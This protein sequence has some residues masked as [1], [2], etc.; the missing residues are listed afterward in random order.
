MKRILKTLV[1]D[2]INLLYPAT[3]IGCD[4][5]LET[6][7]K[8]PVCKMCFEK[9][10][11]NTPPYCSKCGK[12]M[13]K[14]RTYKPTCSDCLRTDVYFTRVWSCCIYEDIIKD[15]IIKFKY[16]QGRY[17]EPFFEAIFAR[18]I[19]MNTDRNLIDI[20]MPVPLFKSK[21]RDRGFNQSEILATIIHK[22]LHKPLLLTILQ[23]IRPTKPQQELSRLAR[24]SNVKD[25]FGVSGSANIKNKNILLVDDVFTTGATINECARVLKRAQCQDIYALTVARG[26]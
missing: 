11:W 16:L 1:T 10:K 26:T 24:L 12:S 18:F 21:L 22:L 8:V 4:E 20:I 2:C 6:H 3:C 23:K 9:I 13:S 14:N 7:D 25:T 19:K 17:L 5:K 15:A